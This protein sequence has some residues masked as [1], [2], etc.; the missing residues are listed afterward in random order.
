MTN[1]LRPDGRKS[2]EMR[3]IEA[4]AGVIDQAD[5]SARFQIGDTEAYA[6][7]YG[8][9]ELHPRHKQD[10]KKGVL[11]CEYNMLPFAGDGSRVRPGF[12]RRGEEISHVTWKALEPVVDLSEYPNAVVD[13]HIELTQTDAGSRCAGICAGSMALADA[14]IQMTDIVP[15][16][17]AG[18]IDDTIVVDLNGKEEHLGGNETPDLPVALIPRDE[19]F[20]LMQLDGILTRD[21][22]DECINTVK[23]ALLDIAEKQREALRDQ[24]NTGA[25]S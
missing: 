17:S 1:S 6:S 21:D 16:V 24:Y 11:R 22:L 23:P 9:Q 3:Q 4:E 12:S 10:P 25:Q 18:K 13:V 19:T 15:A 8:P 14:G 7:V 5:G 2:H 20:S